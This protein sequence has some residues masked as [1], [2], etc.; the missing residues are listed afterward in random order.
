MKY[1][2]LLV[3][4]ITCQTLSADYLEITV[5]AGQTR[6]VDESFPRELSMLI[7]GD[8]ARLELAKNQPELKLTVTELVMGKSVVIS[9]QGR[10]GADG[11]HRTGPG[12]L[13]PCILLGHQLPGCHRAH[14]CAS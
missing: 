3:G 1:L 2:V 5:N 10:N 4:L 14:T 12:V 8:N 13:R 9:T 6:V 7:L 11:E